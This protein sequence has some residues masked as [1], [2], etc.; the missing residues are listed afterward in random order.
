MKYFLAGWWVFIV[1]TLWILSPLFLQW[2]LLQLGYSE[3]D[4]RNT[5]ILGLLWPLPFLLAMIYGWS[6]QEEDNRKPR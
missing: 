4:A 1:T 3:I 6:K 2:V 5:A